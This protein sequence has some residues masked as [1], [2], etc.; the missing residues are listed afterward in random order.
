MLATLESAGLV[1]VVRTR[2]VRAVTEKFYGRTAKLFLFE[3]EDPEDERAIGMS[4]LLESKPARVEPG[5]KYP[6]VLFLH[7]AGERGDNNAAQLTHGS[8]LFTAPANREKYPAFVLFPQV[9]NGER[10]VE[11]D[12]SDKTPHTSPKEPSATPKPTASRSATPRN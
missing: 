8:T 7:G 2:Q 6:L 3:A 11:V 1:H 12:W 4:I 10:W 5:K 9:P